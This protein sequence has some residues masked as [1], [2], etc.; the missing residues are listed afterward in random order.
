MTQI[1]VFQIFR[2]L[3]AGT[4]GKY[5][6]EARNIKDEILTHDCEAAANAPNRGKVGDYSVILLA[7]IHSRQ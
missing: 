3:F 7:I 1:V 2:V 5:S 4:G 6:I